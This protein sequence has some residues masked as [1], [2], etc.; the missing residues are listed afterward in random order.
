MY[1]M[2]NCRE[3]LCVCVLPVSPLSANVQFHR[4]ELLATFYQQLCV[5]QNL[6][7]I[8]VKLKVCLAITIR[9]WLNVLFPPQLS[10]STSGVCMKTFGFS[11]ILSTKCA[12]ENA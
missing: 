5:C 10:I 12:N 4:I 1:K 8:I 11:S 3:Y 9:G 7:P 6:E 2:M